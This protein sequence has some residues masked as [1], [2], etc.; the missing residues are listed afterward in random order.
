MRNILIPSTFFCL[1]I[2][3]FSTEWFEQVIALV[4]ILSF[5]ILHGAN[6]LFLL[7]TMEQQE[8]S[9]SFNRLLFIYIALVFTI[10]VLFF[11]L[12]SLALWSF[13]AYS[14]YHFGEQHW[15]LNL[16]G[17]LPYKKGF[18]FVYGMLI[19]NMLFSFH[20]TE[21]VSVIK[22]VGSY[23]PDP[24]FFKYLSGGAFALVIGYLFWCFP[25]KV[26]VQ[27][28]PTELVMLVTLAIVFKTGSLLW[29]F[30]IYF[31]LWHAIPS[32]K[33]Q[34]KMLYGRV[35][36]KSGIRYLNSAALYW[37][38]S[39]IGIAAVYLFLRDP[40]YGFLPIFFSFLAAITLPHVLVMSRFFK[41]ISRA[42]PT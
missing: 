38:V 37:A 2:T 18:Y 42:N 36:R 4:L 6:D 24:Q 9:F 19:L 35:N 33:D 10:G 17:P 3:G 27:L 23:A 40:Q 7:Q 16:P 29:A 22:T 26:R 5:G 12:P 25:K 32:L 31:I 41:R 13:I 21:V 39:L 20:G 15:E 28:L 1:W 14:A 11:V 30:A 34:V 8:A